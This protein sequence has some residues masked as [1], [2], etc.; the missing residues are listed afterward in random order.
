MIVR[1]E[2]PFAM[3]EYEGFRRV[4]AVACPEFKMMCRR[5]IKRDLMSLY[6]KEKKEMSEYLST[7]PGRICLTSDT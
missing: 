3:V 5:P 2:Q 6:E 1:D 7:V 4:M